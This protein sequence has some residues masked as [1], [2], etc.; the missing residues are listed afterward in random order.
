V[1]DRS[2]FHRTGDADQQCQLWR[3]EYAPGRPDLEFHFRPCFNRKG[4]VGGQ[5]HRCAQ[6]PRLRRRHA[7]QQHPAH[8]DIRANLKR[9]NNFFFVDASLFAGQSVLNPFLPSSASSSTNNLYTSNPSARGTVLHGEHRSDVSWLVRS[10]KL[11][12][13]DLR[14]PTIRSATPT[15][16]AIWRR[17]HARRPPF[18]VT[19][20]LTTRYDERVQD[21]SSRP[22]VEYGAGNL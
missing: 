5:R 12:H 15:M 22:G 19:L 7:G 8:A 20:R 3:F 10:D 21:Q 14:N 11:V 1:G 16:S 17:S 2:E 4:V 18:G 9:S 13:V 6:L